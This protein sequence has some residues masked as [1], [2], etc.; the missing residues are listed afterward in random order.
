MV[1]SPAI[2]I[3]EAFKDLSRLRQ[4]SVI[5]VRHGFADLWQRSRLK[6]RVGL[7][8]GTGAPSPE[9]QRQSTARRF[10]ELLADLGPTFIKLGQVL[11]TRAD[12]LPAEY[13]DELCHLQD[14]APPISLEVIRAQI[15][16][17]L[18]KPWDEA[19]A[20]ID[21]KPLASASI[22]QVHR[23]VTREGAEV[24]IKVQRPGIVDQIETDLD[25]VYYLALAL[26]AVVEEV[27]VYTPSGIVEEFD[28]AIHEE[29]DF[30]NEARNI[31]AFQTSNRDRPYMVIPKVYDD[32][33]GAHVLTMEYLRGVKITEVTDAQYDRKELARK[34]VEESFHQLFDDGLFHA[35][36]HPGNL[37]VLSDKRVG[38]LDFGLVGRL[39]PAMRQTLIM[40][41]LAV[42]LKDPDT[43]SRILYRV[44]IPDT[45]TN[46]AAFRADIEAVLV[47]YKGKSLEEI[48]AG[49]LLRDL[50]DLAVRYRIRIPKEYALLSRASVATEGILRQLD[51][52]MDIA[53]T[54]LPLV[55][56]V[57]FGQ[58]SPDSLQGGLLKGL[59]RLQEL[60]QDVPAQ[61]SQVL[62]DLEGGKFLV[63]VRAAQLDD[64]TDAVRRLAVV[65]MGGMLGASLI[66][67][68]FISMSRTAWSFHGVPVLGVMAIASGSMLFGA[69]GSWYF[70]V[71]RLRKI[72]LSRWFRR[73]SS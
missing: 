7:G 48:T 12:I 46:L 70:V 15:Q 26:E 35:D 40:M 49:S 25:L 68:A 18:G 8:D 10:R 55:R 64:L 54:T 13:I 2:V 27:G 43:V 57:L 38:M 71:V 3:R 58:L 9:V 1:P 42:A 37:I 67:G 29:L 24:A 6:D 30:E 44:G 56:H 50:L 59:L 72:R 73:S 36:P 17:G 31:R 28:R 33:S 19:F 60:S 14:S 52:Q 5:A 63:N 69:V 11:S 39:T 23:G 51:P 20:T 4:I 62:M 61:L 32:L 21:E 66:V 22:A 34:V 47:R 41:T 65:L 53:A 45:R 16:R